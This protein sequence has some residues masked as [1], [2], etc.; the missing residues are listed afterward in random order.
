[1]VQL[2]CLKEN[3]FTCSLKFNMEKERKSTNSML[4]KY[5]MQAETP[6]LKP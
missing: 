4:L 6:L 2:R 5:V 3:K 1:M